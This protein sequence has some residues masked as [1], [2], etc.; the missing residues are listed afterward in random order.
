MG[1]WYYDIDLSD[2]I[3]SQMKIHLGRTFHYSRIFTDIRTLTSY[4]MGEFILHD[5]I[6]IISSIL[7]EP[8]CGI[9]NKRLK[10]K[11]RH[12]YELR[13]NLKDRNSNSNASYTVY[14]IEDLFKKI[15][16]DVKKLPSQISTVITDDELLNEELIPPVGIFNSSLKK[17]SFYSLSTDSLKFILFQTLVHVLIDMKHDENAFK[18]MLRVCRHQHEDSVAQLQNIEKFK[19]EYKSIHA[20]RYYTQDSFL[21]RKLNQVF[22]YENIECI[23][24]FRYYI[25]DLYHQ[26]EQMH[27]QQKHQQKIPLYRGKKLATDVLQQLS[28]NVGGLI[29]MN[30][31][32]STTKDYEVAK[33]YAGVNE[34]RYGYESAV[35][36]INVDEIT[37]IDRRPYANIKPESDIPDDEEYLFSMGFVWCISSIEKENNVWIIKLRSCSNIESKL[38]EH[39]KQLKGK[40]TFLSLGVILSELGE[41]SSAVNFYKRML[42]DPTLPREICGRIYYNIGLIHDRQNRY[43][44]AL[45]NLR[46]AETLIEPSA[47]RNNDM[48]AASQPLYAH[49][50][51]PSRLKMWNNIGRQYQKKDDYESANN[52]YKKALDEPGSELEMATVYHNLG[53]LE[54]DEGKYEESRKYYNMAIA[55]AKDHMCVTEFK[56]DLDIV[57]RYI[58]KETSNNTGCSKSPP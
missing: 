13:L 17:K 40:C 24:P 57:N 38:I 49:D 53:R 31:F 1:I 12:V 2:D 10:T 46:T 54:F 16:D 8:I 9:V 55:R 37:A 20:I 5:I 58:L 25:A 26:L 44:D 14:N 6:F 4:L 43:M 36:E 32:L 45:D 56:K 39:I 23:Y 42:D 7:A 34:Q 29:S 22:R 18:E 3:Y 11:C 48:P 30:G 41:Y 52:A 19:K 47:M 28:D 35:F 51:P 21:F 27:N 15:S 50:I 33:V